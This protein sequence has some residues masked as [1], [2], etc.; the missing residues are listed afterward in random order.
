MSI[1]TRR[2]TT[3]CWSPFPDKLL[4][5]DH[6]R[7]T[8]MKILETKLIVLLIFA[9]W[10]WMP[11][12]PSELNFSHI[13]K[14]SFLKSYVLWIHILGIFAS[15]Q[16]TATVLFTL[17][18]VE[19]SFPHFCSSSN[20]ENDRSI[21][22]RHLLK[23]P[24]A[25]CEFSEEH[26]E[27]DGSIGS[28]ISDNRSEM[29]LRI[30]RSTLQT[31]VSSIRCASPTLATSS[32]V[33]WSDRVP[34][35]TRWGFVPVGR[36]LHAKKP[37]HFLTMLKSSSFAREE[38]TMASIAG[39]SS[40]AMNAWWVRKNSSC[41]PMSVMT[42]M[43]PLSSVQVVFR[44]PLVRAR[45][46]AA[47]SSFCPSIRTKPRTR[48]VSRLLVKVDFPDPGGPPRRSRAA[49]GGTGS[50]ENR[51]TVYNRRKRE[52]EREREERERKREREEGGREERERDS[53]LLLRICR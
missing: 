29:E 52:R 15:S 9:I 13:V 41:P 5:G 44:R 7:Q 14:I 40:Y 2:C 39:T 24:W 53:G 30:R 3:V 19:C 31:S 8:V 10:C 36:T 6:N 1:V 32:G 45:A 18:I 21:F 17:T 16:L 49:D 4:S 38:T 42:Y 43:A 37:A 22:V 12:Q 33:A 28:T 20:M 35:R 46:T 25:S 34:T 51:C 23:D 26:P 47:P 48:L 50:P 27:G 11:K